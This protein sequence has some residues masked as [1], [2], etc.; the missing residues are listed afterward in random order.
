MKFRIKQK[1]LLLLVALLS[2]TITSLALLAGYSTGRQNESAAFTDLDRD[3]R[4]WQNDLERSVVHLRDVAIR[5]VSDPASMALLSQLLG[6]QLTIGDSRQSAA[7]P[8]LSRTL[9]YEKSVALGRML[10]VLRTGGFDSIAVYLHG[11]LSQLVSTSRT[12]MMVARAGR[13]GEVWISATGDIHG[14]LPLQSWPAWQPGTPPPDIPLTVPSPGLP[15]VSFNF[16]TRDATAIEI[17]IPILGRTQDVPPDWGEPDDH[18]VSDLTVPNIS[19]NER[20][21]LAQP[22]SPLAVVVFRK[23]IDRAALQ[24]IRQRT[25]NWAAIFSADGSHNQQLA[26]RVPFSPGLPMRAGVQATLAPVFHRTVD[27]QSSSYYQ[28]LAFWEFDQRPQFILS[29]ASSRTPTLQNVRQTLT[30]ILLVAGCILALSVAV[31]AFWVR[32]FIDPIVALTGAAKA[33]ERKSHT[34]AAGTAAQLQPLDIQASDEV[35]DL[36]AAFNSMIAELRRSIETLEQRVRERTAEVM[37]LA[38]ARSDFLA[39]M[40]HELR[41]PLNAVLGYAQIMQRDGHLDERQARGLAIIQESGQHLLTLINDIL[42]FARMEATKLE[43]T[44]TEVVLARFLQGV[45]DI[46][47]VKAEEKSL[48][49]SL[50][51]APGLPPA[52]R[53]DE[54]RLRQILLNLLGNAIKFT[55]AGRVIL[56]VCERPSRGQPARPSETPHARLRFEVE[57]TGI[58]MSPEQQSRLFHPFAQFGE[59]KRREGGTGLGLAI[60]NVL[61]QLMGGKIELSSQ[62]GKGSHFSFELDLPRAEASVAVKPRRVAT[63]YTSPRKKILV[64]DDLAESRSMLVE[65]LARMGFIMFDAVNGRDAIERVQLVAPDLVLMDLMMPVMDGAEATRRIRQLPGFERL[66]IIMVSASPGPEEHSKSSTAGASAFLP[67]PIDHDVLLQTIGEQL[68]LQWSYRDEGEVPAAS[69]PARDSWLLP[70]A[71]EIERLYQAALVGSMREIQQLAD[72]LGQLDPRYVVFAT[73][74]SELAKAYQS[75]ALVQL[76]ERCRSGASTATELESH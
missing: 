23:L 35:A 15:T 65:A 36:A 73:R 58:G 27:T 52:V 9:G 42:D 43:L 46:I 18:V 47:Q 69:E 67:K 53:V 56:R 62:P 74:L 29:L 24:E 19:R 4:T 38:R 64:V 13:P 28:A 21:E 20:L 61:V 57:D 49:F 3:L 16:P 45:T 11:R 76:L 68:S 44:P 14:A 72:H 59:S 12:G 51:A 40:S 66:P 71:E 34:A 7:N 30:A 60:T 55:D 63:S 75:R 2:V 39:Q 6:L 31:G 32:R 48:Q 1:I 10:P 5:E 26:V 8:E 37:Q 54:K 25:G 50:E 17:A 70:P 22:P 41:T 33:I